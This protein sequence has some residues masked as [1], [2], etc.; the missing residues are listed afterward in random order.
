LDLPLDPL[1]N[2]DQLLRSFQAGRKDP[3]GNVVLTQK[4]QLAKAAEAGRAPTAQ[5][6]LDQAYRAFGAQVQSARK[7]PVIP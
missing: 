4:V 5:P 7:L 1:A 3:F 6:R 2:K